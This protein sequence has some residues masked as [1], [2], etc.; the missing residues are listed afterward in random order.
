MPHVVDGSN[1]VFVQ[2]LSIC[3]GAFSQ[4]MYDCAECAGMTAGMSQYMAGM[5]QQK[6]AVPSSRENYRT[7]PRYK[8][9]T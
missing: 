6:L 8:L 7:E 3:S 2:A 5:S 1:D 9:G 4:K